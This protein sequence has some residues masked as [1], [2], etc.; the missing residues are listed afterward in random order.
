[1]R[2][3]GHLRRFVPLDVSD[4]TL[5]EAAVALSEEYPGVAVSAVVAD[6]HRHLDQLPAG[7]RRLFAFL[8]GTIGNLDPAPAAGVLHPAGQ[9]HDP[10]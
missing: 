3:A 8:G 5:W 10:R 1:M 7:G 6:F 4:T 9:G 2:A